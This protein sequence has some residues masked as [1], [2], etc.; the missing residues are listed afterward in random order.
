MLSTSTRPSNRFERLA[1][2]SLALCVHPYAA[3]RTRSVRDRV[4]VF[5]AYVAGS[6][7]VVLALLQ[8]ISS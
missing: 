4:L 8:L 6:Y 2:R 5:F 3:W 7:A 1:G